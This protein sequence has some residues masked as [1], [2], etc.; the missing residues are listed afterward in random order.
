MARPCQFCESTNRERLETALLRRE[1]TQK[2]AAEELGVSP[3]TVSRHINKHIPEA[4]RLAISQGK[5]TAAG[6][7]VT[8]QLIEI[9]QASRAI[10][11]EAREGNDPSLALKAID[12]VEKQL[13]LQSELLG[14][15]T[16]GMTVNIINSPQYLQF[17]GLVLKILSDYP[18][19]KARL[20]KE[21][22]DGNPD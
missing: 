6:L 1:I 9:N 19:A 12:R 13:R 11:A 17:R 15:I 10:L 22:K 2:A 14:D 21:L 16:G 18:E 7:N 3:Q 8:E 4:V 5:A 20:I